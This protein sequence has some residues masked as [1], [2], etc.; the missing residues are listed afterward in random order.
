LKLGDLIDL[1]WL[2]AE[3]ARIPDDVVQA[4]QPAV[5]A[6]AAPGGAGRAAV[7][8]DLKL[9]Q[10]LCRA[11][12]VAA[13]AAK[14]DLP[15]RAVD[16]AFTAAGVLLA[17]AGLITGAGTA[18]TVLA[19][20]GTTPVNVL[21]F[22]LVFFVLQLVLLLLL[23]WFLL[24]TRAN[25]AAGPGVPHRFAAWLVDRVLGRR[26]RDAAE[27]LRV[28]RARQALYAGVERWSLFTL[29]QY[30]GVAFNVAALTA[31]LLLVTV[32]DLVFSWSTTLG[33][34]GADVHAWTTALSAPWSFWP[35]GVPSLATVEASQWVR[36][37][38]AFVH[39]ELAAQSRH[40]A[41]WWRF[42]AAGLVAYGLLPR[43][44]AACFG[45]V[46]QRRA[47]H[48]AGLD[49]AGF[50]ALY[51]R[52][53]PHHTG[54]AG[55]DPATVRG[56]PPAAGAA[57]TAPSPPAQPGAT[58]VVL[59]WGSVARSAAA[60]CFAASSRFS[61]RVLAALPAGGASLAGDDTA[62]Q[63]LAQHAPQRALVVFA[64]GQQP[65]ADALTFVRSV[66]GK[67][68]AARPLLVL[69]AGSAKD[70]LADAEPDEQAIW[71]RSLG[72]LGDAYLWLDTLGARP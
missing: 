3:P 37:P 66:R 16:R 67:L 41:E 62:L 64:A 21:H 68:G 19:Y 18:L 47:L 69:L 23:V 20:D 31:M 46:R 44:F 13:R 55:P 38:G 10:R 39:G 70:P 61:L 56:A 22:V 34:G 36:M 27:L 26:G 7:D 59:C 25:H 71:R 12:L 14:P 24:R 9:R 29:V 58:A 48:T 53:L 4:A 52:L 33:L 32:T 50:H 65:T 60:V 49:H 15:G 30:F 54:F 8:T 35:A 1:E 57:R 43:L 28:L 63:Q 17:V 11:L 45:A 51:E 42:L 5:V 72:T 2:L 6:A 40:G